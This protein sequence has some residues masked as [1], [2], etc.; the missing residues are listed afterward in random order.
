MRSQT[1]H[2]PA[3]LLPVRFC[4]WHA[5]GE[6]APGW[7][8][9]WSC[10]ERRAAQLMAR[11]WPSLTVIVPCRNEE[12][13]I[14][15][16][17]ESIVSNGYPGDVEI[18]VVDGMSTDSTMDQLQE[19]S[20]RFPNVLVIENRGKTAPSALNIGLRACRGSF[21]ARLDGHARYL[22]GYL[23][24]AVRILC[25]DDRIACAGGVTISEPSTNLCEL[26][27]S[28]VLRSRFG[29]GNSQ[30]RTLV[31]G[32]GRDV[33]TVAFGLYR[34]SSLLEAGMFDE[35]LTRNQDIEMNHRLR[36]AGYRIVLDPACRVY[37]QPRSTIRSFIRQ[38]FENG[39][40]NVW[41]VAYTRKM[42]LSW[43][44]FIPLLFV[45]SVI[46]L[47]IARRSSPLADSLLRIEG[48]LYLCLA[49]ASA[50]RACIWQKSIRCLPMLLFFPLTHLSYGV[51]SLWGLVSLPFLGRH[52]Q[53]DR[54]RP[55]DPPS[56][57][58]GH[59]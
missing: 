16:C 7:R 9:Q 11:N 59:S 20:R 26:W 17:V 55:R 35:R 1:E 13:H 10:R 30:F 53:Q 19:L 14:R 42:I 52:S 49:T 5:P 24:Q 41:T 28:C 43:R 56:S 57:T 40:W 33:D 36:T 45:L 46:T 37:Y 12:Q 27:I 48:I 23:E 15:G 51:G 8:V 6:I 50:L 38:N 34:L 54:D 3:R 58:R 4:C 22:P 29:V 25:S 31:S 44:H 2:D 21:V 32:S 39:K 47:S 18:L